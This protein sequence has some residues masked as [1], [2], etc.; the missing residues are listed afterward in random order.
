[1]QYANEKELEAIK[2]ANEALEETFGDVAFLEFP[3]NLSEVANTYGLKIK[4]GAFKDKSISGAFDSKKNIIY[5]AEDDDIKR[6]AFT[7]AHEIGH[8]KLSHKGQNQEGFFILYRKK[9]YDFK[10]DDSGSIE[11]QANWFAANL[12]MPSDAVREMWSITKNISHLCRFFGVSRAAMSYRLINLGLA[13][14]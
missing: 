6:Q 9:A 5:V 8:S 10:N 13:D 7:I 2:K 11:R 1:M 12:L 4:K 14:D 3:I